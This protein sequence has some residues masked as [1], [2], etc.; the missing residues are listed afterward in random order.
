M[1]RPQ[2]ALPGKL[3]IGAFLKEK[4]LLAQVAEGLSE[5]FGNIEM[6]SPWFNFDFTEYYAPEMGGP[7][8]RRMLVFE[9]LIEQERLAQ[10]KLQ[11][12][13]L[14]LSYSKGTR[15]CVN[16][17]PGH[18]LHERFVLAT[19][20]NYS[21]RIYIDHGIYADLTLIY[22][23]GDFRP[24][25]WTYPDYS[26]DPMRRFLVQVRNKYAQDIKTGQAAQ[27]EPKGR[28]EERKIGC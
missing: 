20:K 28:D 10:C 13:A 25:P 11:T 26:A 16:I 15:R 14:E 21:H 17:D 12:N 4:A 8:F 9:G 19:G 1:S 27:I 23:D 5:A 6:I 7:L 24:L 18:L 2:P 22:R 3:V